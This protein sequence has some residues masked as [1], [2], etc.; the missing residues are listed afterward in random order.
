LRFYVAV[1]HICSDGTGIEIQKPGLVNKC[2]F[3]YMASI[4]KRLGCE[5]I[6][7][8]T[9][10]IPTE[11]AARRKAINNMCTNYNKAACTVIHDRYLLNY[12]WADDGSPCVALV[13]S[14]W[15]TRGWAALELIMSKMVKVLFKGPNEL[16]RVIKDLNEDILAHDPSRC[17]RAHWIASTIIR[18]LRQPIRNITDLMAVLKSRS[19]SWPRG[20]MT[21]AGLLAGLKFEE[22]NIHQEEI[23]KAVI[24]QVVRINPSSLL[25]GQ[26]TI[27]ES[28]G[29]SWYPPS[30]YDMHPRG[31]RRL[32]A[33]HRQCLHPLAANSNALR[34]KSSCESLAVA[35]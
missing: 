24:G 25:H 28:G 35:T 33:H 4:T 11:Q 21:I 2:L 31:S 6:W 17:S 9:I 1:S 18:R 13:F 30:L 10:S 26:V 15:F 7:W 23:T 34:P 27:A 29:W 19:T 8:D 5:A 22:Y 20:R 32:L 12:E 3:D 16:E 14:P